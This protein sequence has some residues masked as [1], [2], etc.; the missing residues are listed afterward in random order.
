MGRPARRA[1]ARW[2]LSVAVAVSATLLAALWF[3][4]R[5]SDA[6]RHAQ[7]PASESITA[8][9]ARPAPAEPRVEA[10]ASAATSPRALA[11]DAGAT[12]GPVSNTTSTPTGRLRVEVFDVNGE[13]LTEFVVYAQRGAKERVE[14]L[15]D[16]SGLAR[17]E[18]IDA[19][20][21]NVALGDFERPL[22][23]PTPVEVR[24]GEDLLVRLAL[25]APLTEIE[26]EVFDAAGRPAPGVDLR[27]RCERGGVSRGVTDFAGRAVLKHVSLG[28]VRVFANDARLGRGNRALE[29]EMFER[30]KVQIALATRE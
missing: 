5:N 24:A 15:T 8:A 17:F 3:S 6:G 7:A 28:V 20:A 11:A 26:V 9:P 30:P 2:T 12:S 14:Q 13:P 25:A 27:T 23:P 10:P 18:S 21:W 1:F 16:G 22:L 4:G 19:G 29:I